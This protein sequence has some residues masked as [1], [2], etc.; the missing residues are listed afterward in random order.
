MSDW[1]LIETAPRD[2]VTVHVWL[3]GA[4]APLPA[5][6]VSRDYLE[7]E[8][9]DAEYME[10]GWYPSHDFYFDL[11]ETVLAPTHWMPLPAPPLKAEL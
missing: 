3:A 7:R 11:P 5:Y 9:D 10:E 8:Y 2:Q 1:Q 4:L 6:F